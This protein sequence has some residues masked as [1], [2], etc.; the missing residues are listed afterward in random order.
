MARVAGGSLGLSLR[1]MVE[2]LAISVPTVVD[3]VR[4]TVSRQV[5]DDRLESWSGKIVDH[6]GMSIEVTGR[7]NLARDQTFLVMSNHQSHYDV[8]VLF[9][10]VGPPHG[11]SLRMIAK[12]E[13]FSFPFFGRAMLEAGF[14]SIDRG[15][16]QAAIESLKRAKERMHSG[17]NVWIAPEGT[18]SPTGKLLPFKKGGFHLALDV[19]EP[20]LPVTIDG[21]RDALPRGSSV[22]YRGANVRVVI[23]KPMSVA[24]YERNQKGFAALSEDV[25]AVIASG[26]R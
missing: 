18:R 11:A 2:T 22:S 20:I 23:H 24:G 12:I 10:V 6:L 17:I 21:T 3:G 16:R 14:I 19:G 1:N 4:G 13:L 25:R 7:D 8:P 15:S 9:H 26:L 5:C